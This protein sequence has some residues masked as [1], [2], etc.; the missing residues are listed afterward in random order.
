MLFI[1]VASV[2]PGFGRWALWDDEQFK[3]WNVKRKSNP[4]GLTPLSSENS[5][6]CAGE[7]GNDGRLL[8]CSSLYSRF[9]WSASIAFSIMGV[10]TT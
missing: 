1:V 7:Q 3:L 5:A 4:S 2:V 9:R 6:E 10:V 8:F